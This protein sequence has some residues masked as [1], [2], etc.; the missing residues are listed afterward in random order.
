MQQLFFFF[1]PHPHAQSRAE[2]AR[3]TVVEVKEEEQVPG[4]F[5]SPREAMVAQGIPWGDTRSN[6]SLGGQG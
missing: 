3:R 6:V 4:V 2:A 1:F 5:P